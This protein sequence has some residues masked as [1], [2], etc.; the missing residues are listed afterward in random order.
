MRCTQACETSE[1]KMKSCTR[2]AVQ[3]ALL[4][5]QVPVQCTVKVQFTYPI[6]VPVF[7]FLKSPSFV[8]FERKGLKVRKPEG[9]NVYPTRSNTTNTGTSD[10]IFDDER[11]VEFFAHRVDRVPVL[12]QQ[13]DAELTQ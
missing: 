5:A 7:Q 2:T 6:P 1:K 4:H 11:R 10:F 3:I 12:V 9:P 13:L 8:D